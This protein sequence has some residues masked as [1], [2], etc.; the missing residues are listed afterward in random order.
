MITCVKDLQEH[1][2]LLQVGVGRNSFRLLI[3]HRLLKD[4]I[5]MGL[6]QDYCEQ[7]LMCVMRILD[8]KMC[9]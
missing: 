5:I 8:A 6:R 4:M 1:S 2:D 9:F 7:I 3:G